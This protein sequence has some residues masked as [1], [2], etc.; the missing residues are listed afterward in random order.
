MDEDCALAC[1]I[2]HHMHHRQLHIL[3]GDIISFNPWIFSLKEI[4]IVL[5]K[6]LGCLLILLSLIRITV[7]HEELAH[8]IIGNRIYNA[9]L[10]HGLVAESDQFPFSD[11]PES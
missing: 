7:I 9:F 3:I 8:T 2:R 5:V 6:E 10:P 11:E 1:S 4:C